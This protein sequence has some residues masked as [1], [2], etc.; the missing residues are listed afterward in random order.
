MAFVRQHGKLWGMVAQASTY[1][2]RFAPSPSGPLHFGSLV[3]A[4]GSYLDARSHD[5]HW[6][7]RIE[8]IDPPR[9]QPGAADD[10]LRTLEAFGLH[11]DGSVLWQS[12]RSDAYAAALE[13]LRDQIF[14]CTCTRAQLRPY[15]G[16]YPGTCRTRSTP[17]ADQPSAVRLITPDTLPAFEDR[18]M[19]TQQLS[20]QD[21]GGDPILRRKDGLWAYQLAVVVDDAA[22]GITD[23]VRGHD[24]LTTTPVQVWLQ[25]C[26]GVPAVRYLHLPVVNSTDGRKLSKQN[27]A[28]AIGAGQRDL[29][30]RAALHVLGLKPEATLC[31]DELLP[32]ASAQWPQRSTSATE[33]PVPATAYT[34][35]TD[36]A[37][38][39]ATEVSQRE[40]T[41]RETSG[42][43]PSC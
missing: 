34:P 21:T 9:E 10:I 31:T 23:V 37:G 13:T 18:V 3:A 29:L 25:Q 20:R 43:T 41:T 12:A 7:V 36:Q 17:P 2:G 28:P 8:D 40:T 14:Y 6:L 4:L 32:W 16:N 39:N 24:L 42:S 35:S 1:V 33:V 15:Q 11:H 38:I 22:Q 5:G 26:L 19:G 30:L 27:H